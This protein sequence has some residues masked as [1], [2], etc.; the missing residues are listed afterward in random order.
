MVVPPT[1]RAE[2]REH[3][4]LINL[5]C[6]FREQQLCMLTLFYP[7]WSAAL[8]QQYF[9]AK[10][11]GSSPPAGQR[12]TS[13]LVAPLWC[14]A[15]IGSNVR[16]I[17]S[18]AVERK[19]TR[20]VT[21]YV[22]TLPVYRPTD[23]TTFAYSYLVQFRS[24][25]QPSDRRTQ[26]LQGIIG[27]GLVSGGVARVACEDEDSCRCRSAA[28][29]MQCNTQGARPCRANHATACV[30]CG[31]HASRNSIDSSTKRL[32]SHSATSAPGIRQ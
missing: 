10:R 31:Y 11:T 13:Y 26:E 7:S 29:I 5:H 2:S 23:G 4:H 32:T 19:P 8:L 21:E 20:T 6:N 15:W 18:P 16:V 27:P 17:P 1:G 14:F 22:A 24:E 3:A 25:Y 30:G 9:S 28:A 12:D